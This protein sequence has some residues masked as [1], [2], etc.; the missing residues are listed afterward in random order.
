MPFRHMAGQVRSEQEHLME[1]SKKLNF[2]MEITNSSSKAVS[3]ETGI[4]PSSISLYRSGKRKKPR[5]AESIRALAEYFSSRINRISQVQAIAEFTD[6]SV[7]LKLREKVLITGTLFSWLNGDPDDIS[8]SDLAIL[9]TFSAHA[10]SHDDEAVRV[11]EDVPKVSVA[12]RDQTFLGRSQIK[13]ALLEFFSYVLYNTEPGTIYMLLDDFN[14]SIITDREIA[15][16]FTGML[17]TLADRGYKF[18]HVV[19]FSNTPNFYDTMIVWIPFYISGKATPYHYPYFTDTLMR[20]SMITLEGQVSLSSFNIYGNNDDI[21]SISYDPEIVKSYTGIFK[22][23]LLRCDPVMQMKFGREA[24]ELYYRQIWHGNTPLMSMSAL[25]P[26]KLMPVENVDYMIAK[27]KAPELLRYA[28]RFRE[29]LTQPI[30]S[31]NDDI[32]MIGDLAS[33]RDIFDGKEMLVM[34]GMSLK[35]TIPQTPETYVRHLQRI[36]DWIE[37]SPHHN[38]IPS[39][40]YIYNISAIIIRKG[41]SVQ[42]FGIFDEYSFFDVREPRLIR[43]FEEFVSRNFDREAFTDYGRSRIREDILKLIRDIRS[44]AKKAGM[45]IDTD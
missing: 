32:T 21:I 44:E 24:A 34:P 16:F 22:T 39:E 12:V 4:T 43:F 29:L 2:L 40:K 7:M 41:E 18:I 3:E 5:N 20:Y 26:A 27:L 9:N 15:S 30:P 10:L 25:L 23:L 33:V 19:P 13:A 17:H 31:P 14:S 38:F 8:T 37:E 1:F 45:N 35:E 6:N 11:R 28:E 36:I 42:V